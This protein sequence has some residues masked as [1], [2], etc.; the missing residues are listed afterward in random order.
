M[1]GSLKEGL[2]RSVWLVGISVAIVLTTLV[3]VGSPCLKV[4]G[5]P[6][7]GLWC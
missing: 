6:I 7:V 4:G 2:S 3:D 5:G 1:E